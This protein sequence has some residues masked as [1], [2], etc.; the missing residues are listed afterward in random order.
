MFN[1]KI[2][3]YFINPFHYCLLIEYIKTP[4]V[5]KRQQF[6]DS[7]SDVTE[8]KTQK[9]LRVDK[10]NNLKRQNLDKYQDKESKYILFLPHFQKEVNCLI[11]LDKRI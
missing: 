6:K 7:K 10:N 1:K 11:N 2:V 5:L 4:M 3:C 8:S 9:R